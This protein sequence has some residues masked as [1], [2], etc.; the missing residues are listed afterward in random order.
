MVEGVRVQILVDETIKNARY[1]LVYTRGDLVGQRAGMRAVINGVPVPGS[2]GTFIGSG[3]G[4]GRVERSL[5]ATLQV[6]TKPTRKN[7]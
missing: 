3:F 5:E 1:V 4:L 7:K 2:V 6:E